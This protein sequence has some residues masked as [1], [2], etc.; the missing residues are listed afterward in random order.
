MGERRCLKPWSQ[1]QGTCCPL[2]E[3]RPESC[4]ALSIS[5]P[6]EAWRLPT[7]G[8]EAESKANE[9]WDLSRWAIATEGKGGRPIP[10]SSWLTF[11]TSFTSLKLRNL[12]KWSQHLQFPEWE[13]ESQR[14]AEEFLQSHTPGKQ[15]DYDSSGLVALE[16]HRPTPRA[17]PMTCR[18]QEGD[19]WARGP[20]GRLSREHLVSRAQGLPAGG[21]VSAGLWRMLSSDPLESMVGKGQW[22]WEW[23]EVRS[24]CMSVKVRSCGWHHWDKVDAQSH[25]MSKGAKFYLECL[26]SKN[27]EENGTCYWWML[28]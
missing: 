8:T 16:P 7:W 5:H 17:V 19:S 25:M 1:S 14:E 27:L 26:F 12:T 24:D 3:G 20:G 15:Q 4:S 6:G 21:G 9:M 10:G 11:L 13:T 18:Q 22:C 2:W 28:F 23:W